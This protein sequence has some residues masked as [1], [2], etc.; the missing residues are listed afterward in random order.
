MRRNNVG[1]NKFGKSLLAA[2]STLLF[3]LNG[4]VLRP[5][6]Q[7]LAD[8]GNLHAEW[9]E[10][11]RFRHLVLQNGVAG[12]HLRIYVEGDGSPWIRAKRVAIDPTPHE[13]LMLRLMHDA[14]DAAA[15][16]GR[17]CYFG[18]ATDRGCEQRW[19][20]FDRYGQ[21]VINSM[22]EAANAI[23]RASGATS[24]ELVGYSGGGTVV[25]GMS[26]CTE[27]IDAVTTIAGNLDPEAWSAFHGYTPLHEV[28]LPQSQPESVTET[29]W[30]CS[31]DENVPPA[32]TDAYFSVRP[33]VVRRVV[34]ACTHATG[35]QRYWPR[36]VR[37]AR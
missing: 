25:L 11:A 4:C 21:V 2:C 5:E 8:A 33:R 26:T 15:Y 20:T 7:R 32:I 29:H 9:L 23:A 14:G 35:W 3:L 1:P 37:G 16:L 19:W 12:S 17:P 22:C 13:P 24:V 31:T 27:G 10:T 6:W 18:T 36:I 34:G 28:D 30:Q